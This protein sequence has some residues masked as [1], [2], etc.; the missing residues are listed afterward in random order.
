MRNIVVRT[1]GICFWC[2]EFL[3]GSGVSSEHLRSNSIR[4]FVTASAQDARMGDGGTIAIAKTPPRTL[5]KKATVYEPGKEE[6]RAKVF[7]PVWDTH[8]NMLTAVKGELE[9][10]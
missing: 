7:R 8:A 2:Q 10:R 9:L 5:A 3:D 1:V 6:S 4:C